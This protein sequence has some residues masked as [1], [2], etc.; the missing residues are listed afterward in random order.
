MDAVHALPLALTVD[1]DIMASG[2]NIGGK[3]SLDLS[4]LSQTRGAMFLDNIMIADRAKQSADMDMV[5]FKS[6]PSGSTFTNNLAQ[7]IVD[8]DIDKIIGVVPIT[9]HHVFVDNSVSRA[10]NLDLGLKLAAVQ[11]SLTLYAALVARS[12]PTFA[13]TTDLSLILSFRAP[14]AW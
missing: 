13:A 4:I 10:V 14:R 9:A 1:T 7:T 2:D 6:D 11:A 3:L 5:L 12:T 8:A